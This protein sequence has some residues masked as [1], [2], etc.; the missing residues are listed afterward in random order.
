MLPAIARM[1]MKMSARTLSSNV[2]CFIFGSQKCDTGRSEIGDFA[3]PVKCFNVGLVCQ[4]FY[5]TEADISKNHAV[6]C[7]NKLQELNT[8][9]AVSV[10]T[11]SELS[12]HLLSCFQASSFM[13]KFLGNDGTIKR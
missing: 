12:Q 13:S 7:C 2:F 3:R 10:S 5:F 4:F 6:A 1:M 11:E 9:V 8:A